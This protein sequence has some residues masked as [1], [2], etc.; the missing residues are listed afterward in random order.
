MNYSEQLIGFKNQRNQYLTQRSFAKVNKINHFTVNECNSVKQRIN[1]VIIKLNLCLRVVN[2]LVN[3]PDALK[4]LQRQFDFIVFCLQRMKHLANI[5]R[6]NQD[7]R[8]LTSAVAIKRMI[9][10]IQQIN[11]TRMKAQV[12][13]QLH[14]IPLSTLI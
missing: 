12:L 14:N 10:Y 6:E 8:P 3:K 9:E 7:C 1:N 2:E 4:L 5:D 11:K 13:I